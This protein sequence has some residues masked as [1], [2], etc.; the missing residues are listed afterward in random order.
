MRLSVPIFALVSFF[1]LAGCSSTGH[2]K[3]PDGFAEVEGGKFDY[4]ATNADGIVVGVRSHANDM[5]GNLDFWTR[6]LDKNLE[7]Q[8]YRPEAQKARSIKTARGLE[9]KQLRY[10]FESQGRQ[11]QYWLTLFV[12][13]SRV[14]VVE[15]GGDDAFFDQEVTPKLESAIQSL[16]VS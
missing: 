6:V 2:L 10:T 1:T 15:A 3:T 11:H 9:G 16:D 14:Y 12:T 8:A 7:K 13:E 5:H 4:R